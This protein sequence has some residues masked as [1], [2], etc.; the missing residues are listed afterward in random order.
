MGPS[1]YSLELAPNDFILFLRVKN[2]SINLLLHR[3]KKWLIPL[4]TNCDPKIRESVSKN[5]FDFREEYFKNSKYTFFVNK[6]CCTLL[7][8]A[9]GKQPLYYYISRTNKFSVTPEKK[10]KL[11]LLKRPED[12]LLE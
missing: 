5:A 10:N 3:P 1:Q 7:G 4:K 11:I 12:F 6:R 8:S 2:K 9:E